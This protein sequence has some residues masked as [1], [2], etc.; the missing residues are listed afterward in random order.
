MQWLNNRKIRVQRTMS[1][2][3]NSEREKGE[4][5]KQWTQPINETLNA[6]IPNKLLGVKSDKQEHGHHVRRVLSS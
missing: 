3:I 4:E 6:Q 1:Q 2:S 5:K